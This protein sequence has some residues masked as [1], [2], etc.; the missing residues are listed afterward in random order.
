MSAPSLRPETTENNGTL[1]TG[2]TTGACAT[3]ASLAAARLLLQGQ[4]TEAA[5][6]RLPRGEFRELLIADLQLTANAALAAVIK[7]AGDDPDATHGAR[8]WVKLQLKAEPGVAFLA[9]QG[10]GTVTRKGLVLPVGEPAINPV[11]RQ[12]I[13]AH[14]QQQAM[15]ADY[16]GGFLVTV[17]IDNGERIALRTMNGRLG[18][19]GGLSVLGTTGIVRP[20]SCSAYIASIHQSIDVANANKLQRIAACTGGTSEAYAQQ[21][22][23]LCDAAIVEMGDLFGAVLKYLR[24]HPVPA[25]ILAAGFGKLTKFAAGHLDTHSRRCAIDLPWLAEQAMLLDGDEVL[26]E[27][28]LQSNTSL[29]ALTYCQQ[30]GVPLAEHIALKAVQVAR[31]YLPQS[32]ALDVCAVDRQGKLLAYVGEACQ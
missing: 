3:A 26:R 24:R 10:V 12:M 6:I 13:V 21:R 23:N 5:R 25:L 27:Q 4:H 28:I 1:R 7:D 16:Q 9:G 31:R 22:F 17:G 2:L 19:V 32:I 20:F 29:Q 11:P 14:L 18:I 15:D 8:L 30:Q